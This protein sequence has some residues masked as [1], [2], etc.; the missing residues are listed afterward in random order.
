MAPSNASAWSCVHASIADV[1]CSAFERPIVAL[2]LAGAA[3]TIAQPLLYRTIRTNLVQQLE[4]ISVDG[5]LARGMTASTLPAG[6][7]TRL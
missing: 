1:V 4:L 7:C 2:F 6:M 5:D 3:R